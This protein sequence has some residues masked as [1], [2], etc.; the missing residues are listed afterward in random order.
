MPKIDAEKREGF[1]IT[2]PYIKGET[3]V[4]TI[5]DF[6]RLGVTVDRDDFMYVNDLGFTLPDGILEKVH[7][8]F[9]GSFWGG[10]VAHGDHW[11]IDGGKFN[12]K[13]PELK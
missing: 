7:P 11:K 6:D 13:L 10:V 12:G 5:N 4:R 1:V 3:V 9:R 2:W 8:F